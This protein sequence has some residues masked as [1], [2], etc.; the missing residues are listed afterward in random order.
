MG[1]QVQTGL[2]DHPAM[3][4]ERR[5]PATKPALV[6]RVAEIARIAGRPI[7]APADVRDRLGLV[8]R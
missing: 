3:D 1:G 4:T 2:E 6:A 7:A 5:E 8:P